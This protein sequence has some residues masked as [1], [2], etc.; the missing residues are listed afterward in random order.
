MESTGVPDRIQLSQETAD[1]ILAAGKTGWIVARE[2]RVHAKGKG[3]LQ[4]YFLDLEE[5]SNVSQG[6]SS[7]N[8]TEEETTNNL[9][10]FEDTEDFIE[11]AKQAD[12]ARATPLGSS[13]N[14]RLVE[15][16]TDILLRHLKQIVAQR[17]K[18]KRQSHIP[19]NEDII[20]QRK[21]GE[22]VID[23]VKEIIDLPGC[24]NATT[25]NDSVDIPL[26]PG[27]AAQ[28]RE[29]M[30]EIGGMYRDNPCT[31]THTI[32]MLNH[33]FTRSI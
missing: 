10:S 9:T 26:D 21:P 5:K 28:L 19:A 30:K 24:V 11:L 33:L 13:K 20:L 12:E 17:A 7:N 31:S 25:I 8:S 29:Y 32:Q 16:N 15:W 18:L 1:L 2:D 27:V 3:M 14:R 22:T 23:E 4:T 6:P